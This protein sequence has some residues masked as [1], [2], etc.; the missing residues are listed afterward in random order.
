MSAQPTKFSPSGAHSSLLTAVLGNCQVSFAVLQW[1]CTR[2]WSALNSEYPKKILKG[3]ERFENDFLHIACAQ[4]CVD[5][6]LFIFRIWR[7]WLMAC[8]GALQLPVMASSNLVVERAFYEDRTASLSFEQVRGKNFIPFKDVLNQGYSSSAFWVRIRVDGASGKI[9]IKIVPMY[10]DEIALF[11]EGRPQPWQIVGDRYPLANNGLKALSYN[12]I[13]DHHIDSP[14][15]WLRLKTTSTNLMAIEAMPLEQLYESNIVE[16][17]LSGMLL[18]TF[19]IFSL[20]GALYFMARREVING[21]FF[22]KQVLALIFALFL[23]GYTR[24]L[25]PG[26]LSPEAVDTL[27]SYCFFIYT[28][29]AVLF[30]VIFFREYGAQFWANLLLVMCLLSVVLAGLLFMAGY[31]RLGLN[32][33]MAAAGVISFLLVLIPI[34]GIRQQVLENPVIKPSVLVG[35]QTANFLLAMLTSLPSLGLISGT[36]FTAYAVMLYAIVSSI[37]MLVIVRFRAI[38]QD[39]QR[40]TEIAL[41]ASRAEQDEST[42]NL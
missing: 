33:N 27:A 11:V 10:L 4:E 23:L 24:W 12:F 6:K 18:G 29:S 14:H 28:F 38:K 2:I 7:V 22:I 1:V 36:K 15:Y 41:Q 25:A 30:Y 3:S 26:I 40:L 34:F 32:A 17:I 5:L 35:I 42:R 13:V 20:T 9:A 19:C 21:A 16:Y 31:R 37:L 8:L 39:Q